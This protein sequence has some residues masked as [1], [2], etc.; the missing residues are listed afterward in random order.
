MF[1]NSLNDIKFSD[2]PFLSSLVEMDNQQPSPSYDK[3]EGKVQRLE[4]EHNNNPSTSARYSEETVFYVYALLDPRKPGNFSYGEFVFEYEPFYIGKGKGTRCYCH[5]QEAIN[6]PE[7]KSHKLNKIRKILL[8]SNTDPKVVLVKEHLSELDAFNLEKSL[9]QEIGF[10]MGE[11]YGCKVGPLTNKTPGGENPPRAIKGEFWSSRASKAGT[12]PWFKK[13]GKNHGNE[14][15]L[16]KYRDMGYSS[17][18]GMIA[19]QGKHP[20]Q[21]AN[22]NNPILA[23][24]SDPSMLFRTQITS[25]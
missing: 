5:I 6:H 25:G 15:M 9:I 24:Y 21:K 12:H 14:C 3:G 19:S 23:Y 8:E 2:A 4:G 20:W 17:W 16:Q 1:E 10:H 18:V 13:F 11:S 22:G 7:R